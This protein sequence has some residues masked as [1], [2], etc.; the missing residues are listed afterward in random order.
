MNLSLIYA[1]LQFG[2]RKKVPLVLQNEAAECGLACLSMISSFHGHEFDLRTLRQRFSMS[3]K[4]ATLA[5]LMEIAGSLK[6]TA[7]PLTLDVDE[8]Q[9]LQL[10]CILHWNFN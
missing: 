9:H 4:G 7:R 1:R 8:I 3:L 2:F 6:L 5:N 10:P